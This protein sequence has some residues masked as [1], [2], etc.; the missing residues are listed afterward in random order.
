M[1]LL[2]Q[3][4]TVMTEKVKENLLLG[5]TCI[6]RTRALSLAHALIN[7]FSCDMKN[8]TLYIGLSITVDV[9]HKQPCS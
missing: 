5:R 6:N 1:I 3:K 7:L 9:W 4:L 8:M 2:P